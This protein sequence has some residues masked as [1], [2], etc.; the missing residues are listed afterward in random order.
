[1]GMVKDVL[2]WAGAVLADCAG[3]VLADAGVVLADVVGCADE[4]PA[5]AM[6]AATTAATRAGVVRIRMV[7]PLFNR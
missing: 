4:H 2:D 6:T 1:L 5:T 7:V 3:V